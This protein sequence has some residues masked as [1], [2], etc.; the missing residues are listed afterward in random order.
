MAPPAGAAPSSVTFPVE[1]DPPVTV[2][3]LS[4]RP[5][6]AIGSIVNV[7]DST[8]APDVAWISTVV[9][10]VTPDVENRS[11]SVWALAGKLTVCLEKPAA[12]ELDETVTLNPALEAGPF[13]DTVNV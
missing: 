1:G 3:G 7:A 5:V 2:A 13:R 8:M 10:V 4:E 11:D 12:L 9:T 6:M